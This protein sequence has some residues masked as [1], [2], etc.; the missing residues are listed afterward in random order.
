MHTRVLD[1]GLRVVVQH[2]P[3]PL[4]AITIWVEAG[5]A[6]ELDDEHGVAHFLEH[7]DAIVRAVEPVVR[8]LQGRDNAVAYR[9]VAG[10]L[11][12]GPRFAALDRFADSN[13]YADNFGEDDPLGWA[14]GALGLSDRARHLA[15][16]FVEDL[17]DVV[18]AAVDPHFGLVRY[19]ERLGHSQ[20]T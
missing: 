18:T 8:F 7:E 14:F 15:T 17:A 2:R 5:C 11:P 19:A 13:G 20:P 16:L 9:I 12:E 1:N 4:A 10:M 3:F 6:D